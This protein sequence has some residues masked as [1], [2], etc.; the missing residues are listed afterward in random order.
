MKELKSKLKNILFRTDIT[1]RLWQYL[2]AVSLLREK[3][4]RLLFINANKSDVCIDIGANIGHASLVLWLKGVKKIYSLEPNNEA[5]KLLKKN[6]KGLKNISIY[7]LAISSYSGSQNLYLHKEIDKKK[8]SES[9]LLF[10]QA[11]SLIKDKSNIGDI[12]YEV[13]TTRLDD[14]IE[15]EKIKPSIIKCDIEGGEYLI[16]DQFIKVAK[17]YPIRKIFIECH[18]K[19][20]P[21]YSKEHEDFISMIRREKLTKIIDLS[22]H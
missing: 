9:E 19:K 7:N 12:S 16:Y 2:R 5:L 11:S 22:W 3:S 8:R 14:L 6:L 15:N 21:V 13:L 1:T 4:F 20:I 18:V 17:S 10:S